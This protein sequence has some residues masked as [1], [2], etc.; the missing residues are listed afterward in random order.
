MVLK[1]KAIPDGPSL[2]SALEAIDIRVLPRTAGRTTR[3]TETFVAVH[4]LAALHRGNRLGYPLSATHRERPDLLISMPS[5][6][7]GVEI[8]EATSESWAKLSGRGTLLGAG[9]AGYRRVR[10]P[11]R[12]PEGHRAG[13]KLRHAPD[14]PQCP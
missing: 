8:A 3:Q 14:P 2:L 7:I 12:A 5:G 4:L 1:L 10:L 13:R 6:D 9:R 11:L